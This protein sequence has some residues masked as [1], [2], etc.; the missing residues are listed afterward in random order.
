[1]IKRNAFHLMAAITVAL[2]G[3]GIASCS[4][5]NDD[6]EVPEPPETTTFK[7]KDLVGTWGLT[8]SKGWERLQDHSETFNDDFDPENPTSEDATKMVITNP[9]GNTL[10][11]VLYEWDEFKKDWVVGN[12]A[13][14]ELNSNQLRLTGAIMTILSV[15]AT[16]LVVEFS[17]GGMAYAKQTYKRMI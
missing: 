3:V 4:S 9:N 10:E 8:H 14:A 13:T 16:Q 7:V 6:S 1:M 5:D 12:S 15:D 11:I 17:V 2:L